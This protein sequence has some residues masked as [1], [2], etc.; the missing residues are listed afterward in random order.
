MHLL[1]ESRRAGIRVLILGP[2]VQ[3]LLAASAGCDLL[4]F[5]GLDSFQAIQASC[6][7]TAR[8]FAEL[9][10]FFYRR[11]LRLRRLYNFQ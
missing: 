8:I 4:L 11:E 6:R 10:D 3:Q 9:L 1:Q 5:V 7:E 2:T